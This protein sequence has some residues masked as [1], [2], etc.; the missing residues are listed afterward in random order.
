MMRARPAESL[1]ATAAAAAAAPVV[2]AAVWR[3]LE[4][5]QVGEMGIV[6]PFLYN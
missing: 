2:A 4:I 3:S 6:Y 5:Y 1:S